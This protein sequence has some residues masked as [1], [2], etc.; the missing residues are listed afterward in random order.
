MREASERG[1]ESSLA[2]EAAEHLARAER[3]QAEIASCATSGAEGMAGMA[4]LHELQLARA[5]LL[6]ASDADGSGR[7]RVRQLCAKLERDPDGIATALRT[8]L[9]ALK[10]ELRKG[11]RGPRR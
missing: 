8:H 3:W 2:L 7:S 4:E 9:A 5:W 10:S 11:S 6:F 1:L